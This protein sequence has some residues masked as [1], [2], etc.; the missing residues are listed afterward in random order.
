MYS[1]WSIH[2]NNEGAS[3]QIALCTL[4]QPNNGKFGTTVSFTLNNYRTTHM[5]THTYNIYTY[6]YIYI[7]TGMK[8]QA[9]WLGPGKD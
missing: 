5:R 1:V 4:R 2:W 9:T 7:S 6:I 8:F 3:R